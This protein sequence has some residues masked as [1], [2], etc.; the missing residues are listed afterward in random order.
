MEQK[1]RKPLRIHLAEQEE[2]RKRQ[3]V[4]PT[5]SFTRLFHSQH[6]ITQSLS[7]PFENNHN[8]PSPS[9]TSPKHQTPRT[10]LLQSIISHIS[11]SS[12][13]ELS[14]LINLQFTTEHFPAPPLD[15]PP[16][17][18]EEQKEGGGPNHTQKSNIKEWRSNLQ[19]TANQRPSQK[20]FVLTSS[21]LIHAF[22][23]L[24]T[25]PLNEQNDWVQVIKTII[26]HGGDVNEVVK[27]T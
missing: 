3:E 1:H 14:R 12:P 5:A 25:C 2:E 15:P 4:D 7:S 26:K 6:H 11:S 27:A 13:E 17:K 16:P 21:P 20:N 10:S 19:I 18:E 9:P 8:S 24:Q 23:G 22:H